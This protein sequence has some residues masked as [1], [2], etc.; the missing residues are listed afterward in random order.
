MKIL[1]PQKNLMD[2]LEKVK[3]SPRERIMAKFLKQI[4]VS[5]G[6]VKLLSLFSY[7]NYRK[8]HQEFENFMMR[9]EVWSDLNLAKVFIESLLSEPVLKIS[10]NQK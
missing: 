8:V 3:I 6:I 5:I 7:K 4:T 9:P 10:D 1:K 2:F